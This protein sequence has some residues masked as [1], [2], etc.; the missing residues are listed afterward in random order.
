[1]EW[2]NKKLTLMQ[3]KKNNLNKK[4][5]QIFLGNTVQFKMQSSELG[6][7]LNAKGYKVKNV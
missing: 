7:I 2:A 1:M 5:K 4:V 6:N 3:R